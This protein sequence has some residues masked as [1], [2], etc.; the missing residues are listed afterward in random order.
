MFSGKRV[1]VLGLA[2]SG[3]AATKLLLKNGATVVVNEY[4]GKDK[5][6]CYDELIDLGATIICGGHPDYLFEEDFDFVVKNPGIPYKKTFI[7]R[8]QERNIPIYS[9]IE[10]GYQLTKQHQ[11]IAITGTNGKTSTTMLTYEILKSKYY[12]THIAGNIGI[13]Y[14]QLILD[15]DLLNKK[16]HIIVLELS[17]FQLLNIDTF[18]PHISTIINL[19]PDHLDYMASLEEYYISKTNIYKNQ[20]ELD[21]FI[22][23]NDDVEIRKYV[24]KLPT[25][26]S[27]FSIENSKA[28]ACVDND[29]IIYKNEL[30]VPLSDVKL[31]GKHN[32][33]NILVAI[34]ICKIMGVENEIIRKVITNFRGVEHRIEYVK[35]I[36]GVKYYNDSKAT[37]IDS[38]IV[39]L[40][41][42]Q[43][44]T[45]LLIGGYE[46]NLDI[47][48]LRSYLT[49][50]KQI[51]A[52][53]ACGLRLGTDLAF[54]NT[55][56]VNQLQDAVTKA[57]ESAVTGDIVLLSPTTS[58]F[59]QFK[60]FEERGVFFKECVHKL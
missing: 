32:I 4:N 10:L 7:I 36:D 56:Y 9:E 18:R 53:G 2:R 28:D 23:N 15:E 6:E 44:P 40:K 58:S 25:S 16:D 22:Y 30:I 3:I 27:T 34:S 39:A 54:E 17:N 50:V 12:N 47:T 5:I 26:I 41:S 46:K 37:N 45:I 24:T 21:Y 14:C 35:E 51:I 59:D 19:S 48:L 31:V 57:C 60:N 8:L 29:H 20:S 42:F 55:V 49:N 13:A 43:S 11:F 38:T 33:Q 1:L 52:Y